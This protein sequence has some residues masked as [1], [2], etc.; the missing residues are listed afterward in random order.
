MGPFVDLASALGQKVGNIFFK[1][2]Q[3]TPTQRPVST[4]GDSMDFGAGVKKLLSPV[5]SLFSPQTKAGVQILEGATKAGNSVIDAFGRNLA[6]S[7]DRLFGNS[8]KAPSVEAR[9][10][11]NA[12]MA[13]NSFGAQYMDLGNAFKLFSA[14]QGGNPEAAAAKEI[15]QQDH[16][17]L[18]IGGFAA[19]A[20][21]MLVASRRS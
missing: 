2:G 1:Q 19:L 11:T 14:I 16:T 20:V 9:K 12:V 3:A 6:D 21:V 10:E 4:N 5:T 15:P 18:Y 8:N 17:M 7:V 13:E